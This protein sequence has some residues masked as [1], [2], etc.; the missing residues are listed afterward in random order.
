MIAGIHLRKFQL[1]AATTITF[2]LVACNNGN[3]ELTEASKKQIEQEVHQAFNE[4]VEISKSLD[5]QRYF[6]LVN[7]EKFVGLNV[8]GTN[9]NSIEDLK[10]VVET[11]FNLTA[12]IESLDFTN[13]RVSVIDH[14]NAIL[15]NEYQQELLLKSGA[16]ISDAGG[17]TQ[18]WFKR[19][20]NWKL[21]SV[22]ASSKP[23][24]PI[25]R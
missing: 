17:G 12:K 15:V 6:Q 22:S 23:G 16:K 13:V 2:F 8:D 19:D 5:T 20:G 14:N 18:V 11:G 9:W 1:I 10:A 25:V 7:A 21:V 24:F 3:S 4:L